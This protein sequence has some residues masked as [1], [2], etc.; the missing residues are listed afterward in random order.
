MGRSSENYENKNAD[1]LAVLY[2]YGLH[3]M[4]MPAA[5]VSVRLPSKSPE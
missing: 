5:G 1:K 2:L 4:I 3:Q